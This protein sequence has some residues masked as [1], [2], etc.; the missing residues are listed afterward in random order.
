MIAFH[1]SFPGEEELYMEKAGFPTSL[2]AEIG[3]ASGVRQLI[4]EK[5][6]PLEAFENGA[7]YKAA[8]I[9]PDE[10]V[11]QCAMIGDVATCRGRLSELAKTGLTDVVF[12][13]QDS[14]PRNIEILPGV[15]AT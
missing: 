13:F 5:R 7:I 12:S 9:V 4:R 1:L 3:N 14:Q 2:A 15:H 11:D 10:F 8:A 6:S